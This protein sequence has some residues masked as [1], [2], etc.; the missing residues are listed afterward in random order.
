MKPYLTTVSDEA[1]LAADQGKKVL[2]EGTQGSDLSLY[3]SSHYPKTTSRDTN[4]SGFLREVGLSPRLVSEI[5]LVLRTFPI[6][7]AGAQ[8]GPMF[9]EISWDDVGKEARFPEAIREF[10]TVSRKLRRIGRFDWA[11]AKQAIRVNRPTKIALNFIDHLGFENRT[12]LSISDLNDKASA[13]IS[14]LSTYGVPV[15]YVGTGPSLKD[16]ICLQQ[17]SSEYSAQ[18]SATDLGS[19]HV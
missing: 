6:R 3:H 8:A 11:A 7:A 5:V 17:S 12:A 13:F 19:A 15:S 14:E 18:A 9:Q 16:N 10:T 1:N 2:I 4:A